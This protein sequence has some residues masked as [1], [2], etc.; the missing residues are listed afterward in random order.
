MSSPAMYFPSDFDMDTARLCGQ[1]SDDA[2]DMY[3]QWKRQGKPRTKSGFT[4]THPTGTGFVFSSPIWSGE[5]LWHF[6]SEVEPFGF[7]ARTPE[8]K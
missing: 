5:H 4:W 2:Y 6:V 3:S 8:G 7:M 1:L